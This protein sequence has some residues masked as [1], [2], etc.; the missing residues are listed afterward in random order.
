MFYKDVTL[1]EDGVWEWKWTG[2]GTAADIV[3]G[4]MDFCQFG[5]PYETAA[6]ADV[7]LGIRQAS[8]AGDSSNH[9]D[10]RT[11]TVQSGAISTMLPPNWTMPVKKP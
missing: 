8:N 9:Y 11:H 2:T 1:D 10:L 6:D 4:A 5:T 7:T 3:T